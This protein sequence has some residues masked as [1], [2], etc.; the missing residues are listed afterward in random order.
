MYVQVTDGVRESVG[1]GEFA[2]PAWTLDYLTAFADLY[3]RALFDYER[4]DLERVPDAWA[5]A[6]AH[7]EADD[8]L[9]TQHALLGVNAHIVHDLAL[10]LD[11]VGIGEGT[12]RARRYGDHVAVNRVLER[13]V[14]DLQTTLAADAPGLADADVTLGRVDE[15]LAAFSV[16][17]AREHAWRVAVALA[18]ALA[19]VRPVVRWY[20][21]AV[22]G[23]AAQVVLSPPPD[24]VATLR[25]AERGG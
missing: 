2:D 4:G 8:R 10:A 25:T 21:N 24:V 3:R 13:L 1:A 23:G 14:E 12:T 16:A 17:E 22:A 18:D 7:A 15:L 5:L 20:L 11:A 19:P 9:V 6:F